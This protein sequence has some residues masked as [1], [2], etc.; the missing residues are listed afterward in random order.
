MDTLQL[1]TPNPL[2]Q[3]I[4]EIVLEKL[5]KIDGSEPH[6]EQRHLSL[7]DSFETR[8]AKFDIDPKSTSHYGRY[9]LR[10]MWL[11]S[12]GVFNYLE[13]NSDN[14]E[15]L[16]DKPLDTVLRSVD[17]LSF[18]AIIPTNSW[19]YLKKQWKVAMV[20][21]TQMIPE[22]KFQLQRNKKEL[23]I[24]GFSSGTLA[25]IDSYIDMKGDRGCPAK[26][27]VLS[28]VFEK[29]IDSIFRDTLLIESIER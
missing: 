13:T 12:R 17:E 19:E 29:Y 24:V 3:N 27:L 6:P 22:N 15:V 5:D 4:Q 25:D 16:E 28:S 11:I 1:R 8:D 21:K 23:Q 9:A 20:G 18:P 26:G 2:V 7:V 14:R 10:D